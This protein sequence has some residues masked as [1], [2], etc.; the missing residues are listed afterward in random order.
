[1]E[2]TLPSLVDSPGL[3]MAQWKSYCSTKTK[4]QVLILIGTREIFSSN[5]PAW[6]RG[7]ARGS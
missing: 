6:R 4:S 5:K 7:S 1:M 3:R 2:I